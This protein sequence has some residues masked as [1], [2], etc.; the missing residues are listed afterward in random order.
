MPQAALLPLAGALLAGDISSNVAS[1]ANIKNQENATAAAQA[2]AQKAQQTAMGNLNTYNKANPSPTATATGP[3]Y[4]GQNI[5]MIGANGQMAA[6][7]AAPSAPSAG[8]AISP[9]MLAQVIQQMQSRQA[10]A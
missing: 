2:D 10:G 7:G 4:A 9:Q 8:G 5:P 6:P 3:K 1:K